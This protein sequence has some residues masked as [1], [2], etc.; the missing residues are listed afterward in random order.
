MPSDKLTFSDLTR[1][2]LDKLKDIYVESRLNSMSNDDLRAFVKLTFEDQIK[3]TVGK[4][5]EREAWK[6]MMD[7]FKTDFDEKVLSV[8]KNIQ[9]NSD[10]SLENQEMEKR[11]KLLEKR[12]QEKDKSNEDMW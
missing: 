11:L 1:D 10:D 8:K 6:E 5:E 9:E 2:E 7:Y 4:E 3:G 12:K